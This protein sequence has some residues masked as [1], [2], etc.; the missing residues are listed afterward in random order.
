MENVWI[1]LPLGGE[2]EAFDLKAEAP[3][4]GLSEGK[5]LLALSEEETADL[6]E[7]GNNEGAER[8]ASSPFPSALQL[9]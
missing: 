9:F 1:S 2:C 3:R 7:M 8:G 5:E 6:R 4:A